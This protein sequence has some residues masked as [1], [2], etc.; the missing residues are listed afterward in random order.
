MLTLNNVREQG[1]QLH[2]QPDIPGDLQT[3][4]H[5]HRHP[6]EPSIQNPDAVFSGHR[7]GHMRI[8]MDSILHDA[9]PILHQQMVLA[10]LDSSEVEL[11]DGIKIFSRIFI[12]F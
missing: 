10:G 5:R 3:S 12:E 1:F 6:A 2:S 8:G 9:G 4:R 11:I 7:E